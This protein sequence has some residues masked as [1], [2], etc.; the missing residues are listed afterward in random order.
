MLPELGTGRR[1]DFP[2][3]TFRHLEKKIQ[4]LRL[5]TLQRAAELAGQDGRQLDKPIFT[6][7]ISHVDQAIEDL[8]GDPSLL[9][10]LGLKYPK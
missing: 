5:E 8:L 1:E 7:G 3:D 9:G 6:V 2:V 10:K 4:T